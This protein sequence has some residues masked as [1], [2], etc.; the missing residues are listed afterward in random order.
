[1]HA[2]GS[3]F[4]PH[5]AGQ[6]LIGSSAS[7]SL[8]QGSCEQGLEAVVLPLAPFTA[9]NIGGKSTSIAQVYLPL[10]IREVPGIIEATWIDE[11]VPHISSVGTLDVLGAVLDL[12]TNPAA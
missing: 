5:G 6:D 3:P 7:L 9:H 12:S 1:M 8:Q 2:D 11:G 10:F 4:G